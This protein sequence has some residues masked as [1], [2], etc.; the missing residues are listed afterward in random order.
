MQ[1][2]SGESLMSGQ[3]GQQG[4]NQQGGNQQGGSGGGWQQQLEQEGIQAAEGYAK[5]QGW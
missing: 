5:K 1:V 4:S 2:F 3:G